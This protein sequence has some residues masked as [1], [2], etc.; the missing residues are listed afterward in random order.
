MAIEVVG[1]FSVRN[2]SVT[3]RRIRL[4]MK[5]YL[6]LT[7]SE[8]REWGSSVASYAPVMK[9]CIAARDSAEIVYAMNV[10]SVLALCMALLRV[11][12]GEV[13]GVGVTRDE[14]LS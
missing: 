7:N 5:T 11:F 12:D 3:G 9:M 1:V 13:A 8:S 10:C 14:P 2:T 6:D 4:N